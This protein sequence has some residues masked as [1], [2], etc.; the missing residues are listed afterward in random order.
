MI[1]YLIVIVLAVLLSAFFSSSEIAIN[2]LNLTRLKKAV[3]SG[4]K[5]AK[6]AYALSE[7]F[8]STLCTILIGNNLV[9]TAATTAATVVILNFLVKHKVTGADEL[10]PVLTTL[11][12][13]V[14]I[15]IIGEILP[16]NLG[17]MHPERWSR[18]VAY[19]IRFLSWVLFPIVYVVTA[20]MKFLRRFW[21][22]DDEDAPTVT[23]EELSTIID[24]VEEEGVIDEEQ[25]ELLQSTLEFP[26]TT[27]REI[28][29]PRIDMVQIDIDDDPEAIL[30]I[31]DQSR[32]SRIP[33]YR[34][35]IDNIIGILVL[36]HYYKELTEVGGR[37]DLIDLESLLIKP[38]FVHKTLRLPNALSVMREHKTHIL[39]VV[40]EFGGTMGIV[41]MEDVLEEL[42]GDIW[43]ESDEIVKQIRK[44]GENTYEV[45]G[46]MNIDDFFAEI[47]H[48]DD[49]FECE[50]KTM[51]GWA[52]EA[53]D[54][55]PHVGD[56]FTYKN[57]CIVVD[58]MDDMRVTKLTVLVTPVE[59]DEDESE[60][61]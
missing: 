18:F 26:E 19:P 28:M 59:E 25:G 9:N 20:A 41:T 60:E 8:T 50:Y 34:D 44:T 29:T 61:E 32:Y 33:V 38:K 24:T 53:T 3:D 39:V 15:L 17:K 23:E 13:T 52:V 49:E 35:S 30:Q 5:T 6:V 55:D 47:E 58:E 12:M 48:E 46:D 11:I 4:D 21:G 37:V 27:V 31:A 10:A 51:G 22:N 54:A 7:N 40:D 42:V 36:N 56:S 57:M 2:S 1:V 14:I 43:D 16:K 45:S